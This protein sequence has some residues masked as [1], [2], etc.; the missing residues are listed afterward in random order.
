MSVPSTFMAFPGHGEPMK[1]IS[2]VIGQQIKNFIITIVFA[3]IHTCLSVRL[4]V[5][6]YVCANI[7]ISLI[8]QPI[9]IPSISMVFSR[10]REPMKII[11]TL[12][13]QQIQKFYYQDCF[14]LNTHVSVNTSVCPSVCLCK[15]L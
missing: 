8:F 14:C 10:H 12:I 11:S 7:H 5:C 9:S 6:P 4:F 15:Y 13:V 1:I 3:Q 2:T